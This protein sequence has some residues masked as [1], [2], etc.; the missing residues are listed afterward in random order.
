[1][2]SPLDALEPRML[3]HHFDEIRKIPRPS[4]KEGRIREFMKAFGKE[5]GCEVLED[6][7]GNLC[8]KVPATAGHEGA[9]TVVLQGHMDMVCEKNSGTEFDFDSDPIEIEIDGDWVTAKGTTLGA[10]NGLGL[11]AAMSAVTD[12]SVVHGPL[13][14][15]FTVDE[16]TGLT[17]AMQLDPSM[18]S[19]KRLLN[20]DSE[21]DGV[22]FVGCA[23]GQ[24]AYVTLPLAKEEAP[25]GEAFCL[26]VKGLKGGHSGLDI[27]ENR[28]NAITILAR[29][30]E[31][32]VCEGLRLASFI[33]GSAHNA[34]PREAKAVLIGSPE[35]KE[36]ISK[37]I[38]AVRAGAVEEY[39]RSSPTLSSPCP[40]RRRPKGSTTATPRRAWSGCSWVSPT[41]SPR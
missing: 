15:L 27:I 19:G 5:R 14:L 9:P 30:V 32:L 24:S 38:E 28:G 18:I 37:V 40:K 35:T 13:E 7:A 39:G 16:E 31:P 33:G 3:W 29:A 1:V 4:G 6:S 22:L 34:I 23:G 26:E 2:A 17:G 41:A 21:D 36:T 8:I 25:A 11:A 20:L 12:E 10:D